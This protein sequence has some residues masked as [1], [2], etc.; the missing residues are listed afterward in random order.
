MSKEIEA[1]ICHI[2]SKCNNNDFAGA[3]R[4][5]EF[6]LDEISKE[7]YF[8]RLNTNARALAKHIMSENNHQT[9]KFDTAQLA[10]IN[11]INSYSSS[12]DIPM[13]KRILR[14]SAELLK[15]PSITPLL[16]KDAKYLLKTMGVL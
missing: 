1:T 5:L 10:A 14:N 8:Q 2:N 6:N 9:F 13:L 15:N 3:R 4:L 12:F 11:R 16:N 7:I